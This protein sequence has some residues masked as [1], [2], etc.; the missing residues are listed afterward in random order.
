M[1]SHLAAYQQPR[2][3]EFVGELPMT[4]TGK[5]QRRVLREREASAACAAQG[6]GRGVGEGVAV[7]LVLGQAALLD[8]GLLRD[9]GH[10]RRPAG[11]DLVAGEAREVVEHRLVDEARAAQPVVLA[12][13]APR[14]PG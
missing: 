4:T 1:K 7:E 3:I 9:V 6:I 11:V 13:A 10:R 5:V 12:A 14:A 8:E 2:L